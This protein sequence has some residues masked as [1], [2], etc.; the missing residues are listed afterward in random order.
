W[1]F[2]RCSCS[3]AGYFDASCCRIHAD[4]SPGQLDGPRQGQEVYR[5]TLGL[6]SAS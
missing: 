3:H 4:V 5:Y 1:N 6:P 2:S